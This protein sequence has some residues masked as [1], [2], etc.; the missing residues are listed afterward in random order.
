MSE[1]LTD[2]PRSLGFV[3]AMASAIALSTW[4]ISK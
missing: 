2:N 3:F 1:R 4:A